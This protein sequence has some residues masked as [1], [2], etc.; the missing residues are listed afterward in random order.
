[1]FLPNR[2]LEK[3]LQ[4]NSY[5]KQYLEYIR[6]LIKRER[7]KCRINFIEAFIRTDIIRTFLKFR[8][9]Y[10]GCFEPTETL[11]GDF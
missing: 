9:A 11:I 6:S 5:W 4:R 2:H 8:I 1:M 7:N 10:N 3:E